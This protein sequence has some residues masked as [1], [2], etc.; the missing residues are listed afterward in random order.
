MLLKMPPKAE[1]MEETPRLLSSSH[2]PSS[3][4]HLPFA[5]PNWSQGGKGARDMQFI[6]FDLSSDTEQ[7]R[8]R[9]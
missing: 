2:S 1:R 3:Y 7:S 4:Q 5:E 8:G 6:G 9:S